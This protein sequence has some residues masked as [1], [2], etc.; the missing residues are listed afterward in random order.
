VETEAGFD[1]Y[2]MMSEKPGMNIDSDALCSLCEPLC[3]TFGK[4]VID[5]AS[6]DRTI[7]RPAGLAQHAILESSYDP[8]GLQ[9]IE[10]G[11]LDEIYRNKHCPFCRLV[12]EATHDDTVPGIGIDGLS[13]EGKRVKCYM[14]WQIDTREQD[15]SVTKTTEATNLAAKTRRIR[16][17]SPSNEFPDAH[18]SLLDETRAASSYLGRRISSTHIDIGLIRGWLKICESHHHSRCWM[19]NQFSHKDRP[20]G[21][22]LIDVTTRSI[23][24]ASLKTSRFVALSYL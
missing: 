17:F 11:H 2:C 19:L 7:L 14:A 21:F 1:S 23:V 18:I 8:H 6:H 5:E 16:I 10:L 24:P 20:S 4:F 3:I 9:T 13:R 22:R 12:S 15:A